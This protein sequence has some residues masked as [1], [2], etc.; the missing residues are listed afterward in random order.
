MQAVATSKPD[1][2]S[3][4]FHLRFD[5][6]RYLPF[7]GAGAI[8]TWRLELPQ[9]DN[10]LDLAQIADV[11]LTL[12]YTART[13]GA[14]LEAVARADRE[15]GLARGGIKPEAQHSFSL[16]RDAPG[17]VEAARGDAGRDRKSRSPLP[18]EA[19]RF[20][21]R[22]RGLD[23]RIERVTVFAQAR[24]HARRRTPCKLRLDPPKGS[25]TPITGWAPPWP[26]SRTLRA[27]ADVSGPPGAWKLAVSASGAK[28]PELVDDLVFVFE[29]R[30]RKT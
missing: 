14:A 5:D 1:A 23:L 20:S 16:K 15:K 12:A 25:G 24:R 22:Y 4:L 13:G 11:V 28:M 21:G 9:A 17:S 6:E 7:E 8:S 29:L 18:L 19:D 10:A 3:G 2:D 27:T 30:A 26:Q